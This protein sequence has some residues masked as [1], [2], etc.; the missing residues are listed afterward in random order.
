MNIYKI[1]GLVGLVLALIAAFTAVPY[2]TPILA[3]CG[4]VVGW[5]TPA[6][7]HVRVIA[8]AMALHILTATFDE[9]PGIG[10]YVTGII[11]N[12]GSILAG[13]AIL[14]IFRNIVKRIKA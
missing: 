5:A 11:G 13:A 10:P 8:S 6:D 14:I 4:A 9:V 1:F 3:I 12:V 2:A 7:S